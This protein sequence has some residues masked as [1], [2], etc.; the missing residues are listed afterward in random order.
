M[1]VDIIDEQTALPLSTDA[2]SA[3]V[4]HVIDFEEHICDE[5]SVHFVDEPT[6][7]ELHRIYFND[8]SPTDCISFPLESDDIP[9]YKNIG[10]VFVCPQVAILYARLQNANAYDEV[11]LYIVHG[12]LHLMGYDDTTEA[13]TQEMREAEVRHLAELKKNG[14]NLYG[15]DEKKI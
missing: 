7:C 5:V 10:N 6:I 14:L 1:H 2:V 8:P 15:K 11:T 9:G 3:I 12:L 4:K 13:L